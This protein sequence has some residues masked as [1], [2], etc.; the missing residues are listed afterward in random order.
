MNYKEDNHAYMKQKQNKNQLKWNKKAYI[1][2]CYQVCNRS[3]TAQL[4]IDKLYYL[5][6]NLEG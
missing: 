5:H 3:N 2:G 1:V 6:K 4:K